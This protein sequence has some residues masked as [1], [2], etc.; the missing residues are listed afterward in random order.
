MT[1]NIDIKFIF[2]KHREKYIIVIEASAPPYYNLQS[3]TPLP[4]YEY[5]ESNK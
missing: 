5:F 2:F 4:K 1:I 3:D